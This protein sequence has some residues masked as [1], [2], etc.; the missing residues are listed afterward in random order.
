MPAEDD[1]T[2][3]P[4]AVAAVGLRPDEE[5]TIATSL[6][7]AG[8]FELVAYCDEGLPGHEARR[9]PIPHYTDYNVLLQ[10][11]PAEL[12]LVTGPVEK[13]R[14]FAVR[15]LN[16]GR[17]AVL[18]LPFC[19]EAADA[20][21]VKR[22]AIQRNLLAT[23]D[24]H[25]RLDPDFLAVRAALDAENLGSVWGILC[26][27]GRP[28]P[29]AGSAALPALL[30]D[31]GL[32]I[33]DQVNLLLSDDVRSVTAHLRRPAAQADETSFIVH[34]SLRKGG[35][36]AAQAACGL[37]GLPHWTLYG[38][39]EVI[40]AAGGRATVTSDCEQRTYDAMPL[41]ETF[42]QNLYEAIRHGTELLYHPAGIVRAMKLLEAAR[43]SAELG[44]AVTI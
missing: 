24:L 31:V 4:I 3:R 19:E 16:S 35:W 34:M 17:H 33:L 2:Q 40:T 42:W 38:P 5:G 8:P 15:A 28:E 41:Q 13:R 26:S 27:V 43:E 21:R 18:D 23:A 1:L 12:V 44:E 32:P 10:E 39:H 6:P 7:P 36:A 37:T 25:W 14:D 11:S 30:S 20:E 22:T 9:S 29:G